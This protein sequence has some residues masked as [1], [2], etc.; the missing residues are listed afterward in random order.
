MGHIT[1]RAERVHPD[2]LL[3][4]I[5]LQRAWI[6]VSDGGGSRLTEQIFLV[7]KGAS[8]EVGLPRGSANYM[9]ASM[10]R[11]WCSLATLESFQWLASAQ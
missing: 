7:G 3:V 9:L 11:N 2:S 10:H 6:A 8:A 5:I 4:G 1:E